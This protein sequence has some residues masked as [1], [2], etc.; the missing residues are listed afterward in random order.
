MESE[1][2]ENGLGDDRLVGVE[3]IVNVGDELQQTLRAAGLEIP[4]YHSRQVHVAMEDATPPS[5]RALPALARRQS[6]CGKQGR[7]A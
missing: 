2:S 4:L 1:T 3:E 6:L 7:P 5:G